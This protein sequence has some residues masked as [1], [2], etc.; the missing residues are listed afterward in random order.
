MHSWTFEA[1]GGSKRSDV[2]QREGKRLGTLEATGVLPDGSELTATNIIT[3]VDKDSFTW[4]SVARTSD[5]TALPDIA[6]VKVKRVK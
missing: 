3:P 1:G 2:D 5:G 6:P 4:Q